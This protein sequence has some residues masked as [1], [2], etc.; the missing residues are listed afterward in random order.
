MSWKIT[1]KGLSKKR[2]PLLTASA[3]NGHLRDQLTSNIRDNYEADSKANRIS[4]NSRKIS[5]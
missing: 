2:G 5:P 1:P 4:N 3:R